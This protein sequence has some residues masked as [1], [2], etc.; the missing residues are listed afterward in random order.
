MTWMIQR[1]RN[2]GWALLIGAMTLSGEALADPAD[3]KF[4]AGFTL[5]EAGQFEAA[6]ALYEEAF[7]LRESP[8]IAA[9]L[10][11]VKLQLGKKAEAAKYLAYAL[12]LM[13]A[14]ADPALR[15][16]LEETMVEVKASVAELRIETS[17]PGAE[18]SVGGRVV[19]RSPLADPLYFEPG[20]VVIRAT[21]SAHDPAEQRVPCATGDARE[22]RLTLVPSA[23]GVE[24]DPVATSERPLWP[25]FVL[26]GVAAV[27]VGLGVVGTVGASGAYSDAEALAAS[28]ACSSPANCRAAG[29]ELASDYGSFGTM[30]VV[31]FGVGAA[32]LTG[33]IIYLVLPEG[34][35]PSIE[36]AFVVTPWVGPEVGGLSIRVGL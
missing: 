34:S 31:G 36:S 3:D 9:N 1:G 30:G 15:R 24:P 16:K 13:P 29:D 7:G 12:R 18:I 8:D 10:A 27:G 19:G 22:V 4:K 5:F 2:L 20:E 33:M 28:D 11:Q 35:D 14:T 21:L 26:G 17:V 25:A 6:E 32:A 23:A